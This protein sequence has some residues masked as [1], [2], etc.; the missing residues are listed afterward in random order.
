MTPDR[1]AIEHVVLGRMLRLNATAQGIAVGLVAGLGLFV[2]TN[3]LIL[4]GGPV[5]GPNLGL[6]GQF[7]IGYRVSF[8]GSLVGLGYGVVGGFVIGYGVARIYNWLVDRRE[9]RAG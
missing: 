7:L 3:W 1:Q 4:K 2:A 9:R 5:V 8:A 6:L